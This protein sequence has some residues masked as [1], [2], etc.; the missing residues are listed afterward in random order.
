MQT[1][2]F[3]EHHRCHRDVCK[4]HHH[5]NEDNDICHRTR[6]VKSYKNAMQTANERN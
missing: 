3:C 1:S 4:H 6:Y 5:Y 2:D